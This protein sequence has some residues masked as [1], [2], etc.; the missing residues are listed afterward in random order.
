LTEPAATALD[1]AIA[2]LLVAGASFAL[3]GSL[4]LAKLGDFY[5]RLHGPTKATTLGVG[6]I[7][8]ASSLF[9][10]VLQGTP[11]LHELLVVLFLFVTAPVSAQLLVKS[12]LVDDARAP[13]PPDAAGDPDDAGDAGRGRDPGPAG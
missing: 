6:A 5:R 4:G 3:V 13:R 10:S 1:W 2:V 12:A 7:L 11:S 9:F 8:L